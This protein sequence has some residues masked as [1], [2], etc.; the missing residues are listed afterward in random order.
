MEGVEPVSSFPFSG[1]FVQP[2]DGRPI[3][4][5]VRQRN[6]FRW[7]MRLP[8]EMRDVICL[9]VVFVFPIGEQR[10]SLGSSTDELSESNTVLA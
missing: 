2:V 1:F 7:S 9:S 4:V 10:M 6:Q 5:A 3:L 8:F